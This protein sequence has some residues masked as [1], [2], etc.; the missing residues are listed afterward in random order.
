MDVGHEV[1]GWGAAP[2]L[3][4]QRVHEAQEGGT[5]HRGEPQ[6]AD[7]PDHERLHDPRTLEAVD[8]DDCVEKG[9]R[10]DPLRHG[11]GELKSYRAADVVHHEMEAV[12]LERVDRLLTEAAEPRPGVVEV[13]RPLR[14]AEARQVERDA[15]QP[16]G[17]E[18]VDD[19]AVEEAGGR[20]AV[21]AHD[22]LAT[23]RLPDEA[24]DPSG[25]EVPA[26]CLVLADDGRGVGKEHGTPL[27]RPREV[28]WTASDNLGLL[29]QMVCSPQCSSASENSGPF[30]GLCLD[31]DWTARHCGR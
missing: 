27:P 20:D 12:K 17:G 16:A 2:V 10:E 13:R 21:Q 25:G 1:R 22:G 19:L 30:S 8:L 15:A 7:S 23:S 5:R 11:R 4:P 14:E 26:G 6:P 3:D 31:S 29:R 18:L 24:L 28:V 9:E